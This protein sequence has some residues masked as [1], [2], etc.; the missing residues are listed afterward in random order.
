MLAPG[1]VV[2]ILS[3]GDFGGIHEKLMQELRRR[4]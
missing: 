1:D 3:N 2:V 4:G